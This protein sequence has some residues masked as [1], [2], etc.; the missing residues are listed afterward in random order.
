M[1]WTLA[2]FGEDIQSIQS[3]CGAL[4]GKQKLETGTSAHVQMNHAEEMLHDE[5]AGQMIHE[6]YRTK[7]K[8]CGINRT[9]VFMAI[10]DSLDPWPI[11]LLADNSLGPGCQAS[12]VQ[13]S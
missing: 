3:H 13:D 7:L 12:L 6:R 10:G 11:K 4:T 9:W 5:P 1:A 2:A 8:S